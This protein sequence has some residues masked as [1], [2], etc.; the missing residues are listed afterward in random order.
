MKIDVVKLY[1]NGT[2]AGDFL[3]GGE[4]KADGSKDEKF[5][6]S[7]QNFV[8][9]TGKEVILVDTGLSP[10]T[11]FKGYTKVND[12]VEGFEKLGYK[13][14]QVTKILVT[15]K[16]P[17]HSG[18]L[19][20]FPNAKIY[21]GPED[22]DALKLTGENVIRCEYTDGAY[23]NFEHCQKVADGVYF[24]KARGHTKG[25]SIVIAEGDDGVYYMMHGDVT[26]ND[27]ALKKN[28]LSIV[29][30]DLEAARDTLNRVREFVKNNPTIYLST[31]TPEGYKNLEEKIIMKLD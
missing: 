31:H 12:Y 10:E 17:D 7:L 11:P 28:K 20:S 22:A 6:G 3:F 21:I 19:K 29:Y 23:K 18:E 27:T 4:N 24:I 15:H 9:D 14:E 8:I 5:P 26:Y 1:D 2:F 16:H 30:E 25:N 13:K